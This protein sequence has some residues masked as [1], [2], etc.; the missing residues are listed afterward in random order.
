M[1]KA[2][3]PKHNIAVK[4][5]ALYENTIGIVQEKFLVEIYSTANVVGYKF[6]LRYIGK[7]IS[8]ECA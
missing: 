4:C 8:K 3:V 7:S 1:N 6:L 2:K 5:D